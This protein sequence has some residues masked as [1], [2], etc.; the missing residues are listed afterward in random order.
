MKLTLRWCRWTDPKDPCI[1][2]WRVK[3]Q[4]CNCPCLRQPWLC[5]AQ[6]LFSKESMESLWGA[7]LESLAARLRVIFHLQEMNHDVYIIMI[8]T[9]NPHLRQQQPN[10]GENQISFARS[11]FYHLWLTANSA[12]FFKNSHAETSTHNTVLLRSTFHASEKQCAKSTVLS[13]IAGE[14]SLKIE[15]SEGA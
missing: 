12:F 8:G 2:A 15:T 5:M 11:F 9:L 3:Y 6:P 14:M 1:E 10:N 7:D 13:R 4:R